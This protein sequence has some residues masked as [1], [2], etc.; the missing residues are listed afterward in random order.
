MVF[1]PKG[2]QWRNGYSYAVEA[3]VVGKVV[4]KIEKR[5]GLVTREAFL[6]ASRDEK[7]PTHS[8]FEWDDTIAAEKWRLDESRKIITA[9]QIVYEDNNKQEKTAPAVINVVAEKTAKYQNIITALS[10]EESR[11]L[12]IKRL[13]NE[14]SQLIERNRHIDELADILRDALNELEVSA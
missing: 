9:L 1:K 10:A 8:M 12:I 4:E 14:V 2:Y 13:K 6:D 3:K 11:E 5:D 7:S